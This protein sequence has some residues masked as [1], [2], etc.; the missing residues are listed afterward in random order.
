[1]AKD[2]LKIRAKAG[3]YNELIQVYKNEVGCED[4]K[5]ISWSTPIKGTR[6]EPPTQI[7][8]IIVDLV[9]SQGAIRLFETASG[10]YLD[11]AGTEEAGNFYS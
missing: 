8:A 6:I 5:P 10:E 11:G 7:D 1:M 3:E 2:V 4:C 9:A